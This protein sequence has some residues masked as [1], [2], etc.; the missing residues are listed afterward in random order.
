MKHKLFV[1]LLLICDV[2][3][4]TITKL[5]DK[6]IALSQ[7]EMNLIECA[8]ILVHKCLAANLENHQEMQIIAGIF[9]RLDAANI[10]DISIENVAN[11]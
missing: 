3:T 1:T 9:F 5:N 6:Q 4:S 10:D 11:R 7:F 2:E 8:I